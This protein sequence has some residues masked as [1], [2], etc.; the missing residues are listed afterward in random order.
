M[1]IF[2]LHEAPIMAASF[3]CDRHVGKMLLES[4]QLLATAHHELGHPVTY[5]PTHRNHPCA[6]WVRSSRL[7]Y[8][9]V[10]ELAVALGREF[11]MRF[12]K[13]HAT[14]AVVERELLLPPE[15]LVKSGWVNPP[16][17]MPEAFRGGDTVEAYRRY[18]RSKASQ[19][20]MKWT[21]RFTPQWFCKESN[22]QE[23]THV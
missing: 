19:F 20:E 10:S 9:Y 4:A 12:D 14:L 16:Q 21:R 11:R 17:C 3:H 7:H 6:V 13:D 15:P 22:S 2:F 23:I 8:N 5:K 18:Y 1:N